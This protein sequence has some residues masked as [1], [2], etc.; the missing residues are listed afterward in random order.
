[1]YKTVIIF[2][3][4]ALIKLVKAGFPLQT[5]KQFY[6]Y[7][8]PEVIDET[9]I[10]GKKGFHEDAY[11]IEEALLQGYIKKTEM[12][13]ISQKDDLCPKELFGKGERSIYYAQHNIPL[14]TIC[15]DDQ[16]FLN[17]LLSQSIPFVH[18][19]D[20]VQRMKEKKLIDTQDAA[21]ILSKLELLNRRQTP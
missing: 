15:S 10:Q 8:T 19:V 11:F 21:R 16:K 14:S 5:F 3:S 2:D 12:K 6:C 18:T 4:D 1:M 17:F 13:K 9:I 20:L 7:I